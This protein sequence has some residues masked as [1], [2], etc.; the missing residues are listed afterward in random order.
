M[1][2]S[3]CSEKKAADLRY[4]VV[5]HVRISKIVPVFSNACKTLV[6]KA[7]DEEQYEALAESFEHIVDR[8]DWQSNKD[9]DQERSTEAREE[10]LQVGAALHGSILSLLPPSRD[11]IPL[12]RNGK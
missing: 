8:L 9:A 10:Q 5:R 2:P 12:A 7:G 11:P 4:A 1:R 3:Y 6:E